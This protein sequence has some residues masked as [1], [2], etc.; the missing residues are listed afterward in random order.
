MKR[1]HLYRYICI[2]RF[3]ILHKDN[4]GYLVTVTNGK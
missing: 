2:G 4:H 3:V 1:V